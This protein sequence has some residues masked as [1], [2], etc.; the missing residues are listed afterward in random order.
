M[1]K[2]LVAEDDKQIGDMIAFKLTNGGH[3]V[4]RAE[5]GEQAVTLA[6]RELPDL[7]LLDAMMPGLSG[8][9]VLRRLKSDPALRAVPVIMVTAKGHERDVLSGLRGGA[10][11]YVVKPFSLKELAARVDLALRK[12][13]PATAS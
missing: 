9:E 5:D 10:V 13:P 12:E 2:I 4:I 7:I 6:A 8:F 3:Q 11:D 1:A